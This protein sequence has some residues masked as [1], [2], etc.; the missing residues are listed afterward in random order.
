M[1]RPYSNTAP[2]RSPFSDAEST[3]RELSQDY[4]TS[5][6][7]GN[8]DHVGAMFAP[9][10]MF[11][12][13][14]YESAQGPKAIERKLREFGEAGYQDLRYETIFV[15]HSGD[16]AVEIG[17]YTMAVRQANGTTTADRGKYMRVWRRLGAWLI[18][19]DSW[20]SSLPR[21]QEEKQ[22][23]NTNKT[24]IIGHDVPKSA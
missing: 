13:P 5:I 23:P 21:L 3:I 19:G 15:E 6:N 16:I 17:R 10:G 14:H 24:S 4:C 20:S 18:V 11:M 12:V 2:N 9:E 1:Y 7:T 22:L 8:Y